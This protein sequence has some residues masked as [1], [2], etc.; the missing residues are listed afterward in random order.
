MR[1]AVPI[2]LLAS[3]LVAAAPTDDVQRL[4]AR[5]LGDTPMM[6]DLHELTDRIGGRITGSPECERAIDW[7]AA[8]L[9]AAGVKVAIE[10]FTMPQIWLPRTAEASCVAPSKFPLRIA[11]APGTAS[12][13]V[14][15]APLVDAGEGTPADYERL[16]AKAKG[17]IALVHSPEMKTFEDLFAEYMKCRAL[18]EAARKAGASALLIE[19]SRP[20]GLLYRHPM[21]FNANLDPLPVAVIAREQAER[22]FR[23]AAES[24]V[25][26][27]LAID[28]D[29]REK[30]T[31][32]NVIGEIRGTDKAAEVVLVGAHLDAYDLGTGANDNG[33]SCA[34]LI[35]LA[36]Q[37]AASGSKPRRTIRFALFTGEEQGMIGSAAYVRAHAKEL[38]DH[39]A[40]VVY[41]VGSG[42][43]TGVFLNGREELRPV[44]ERALAALPSLGTLTHPID[45]LDGTDNFDFMLA[46]IPNLV[47]FQDPAPYLPDYHAESDTFDKVDA[48]L[49]KEGEA[50]LAAIVWELANRE[51]R[52]GRRQTRGEVEK[53]IQDTHLEEQMRAFGQWD[54]WVNRRRGISKP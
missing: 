32:R 25:R 41:D 37:I 24:P 19:S 27:R 6:A 44:V 5:V 26:I 13:R 47:G 23:L 45:A 36:R 4:T 40:A 7:A 28:N 15:E 1:R 31:S 8:K 42:K 11:A 21:T 22:L 46:G 54:D 38:D 33:V 50:A 14:L 34:E 29:V 51:E 35:D 20:R 39:V 30:V 17:A 3:A 48:A 16:G 53:L 9:K 49:A 43:L 2:A 18:L 12:L 10:P 52:P